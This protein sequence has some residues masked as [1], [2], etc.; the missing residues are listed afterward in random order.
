M[1]DNQI[2]EE[3]RDVK[4]KEATVPQTAVRSAKNYFKRNPHP[5]SVLVRKQTGIQLKSGA[6]F[7][8]PA[9]SSHSSRIIIPNKRFLEDDCHKVEISPK[10]PKVENLSVD[11]KKGNTPT[12][13]STYRCSR[14]EIKSES[15]AAA[16]D[17]TSRPDIVAE[18]VEFES[19]ETKLCT[20]EVDKQDLKLGSKRDELKIVSADHSEAD[21]LEFGADVKTKTIETDSLKSKSVSPTGSILQKPKLRLDQT[22]VD[23]SKVEFAKS[24]RNQMAQET[25]SKETQSKLS[26]TSSFP[27]SVSSVTGDV[28]SSE[29]RS[30][31]TSVQ[32]SNNTSSVTCSSW[33]SRTGKSLKVIKY[34]HKA[35]ALFNHHFH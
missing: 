9:K 29:L 14:K 25:Q 18:D 33:T 4:N 16:S 3:T 27:A 2:S 7:C 22:A 32:S 34:S 12:V 6:V 35:H 10:K 19:N 5:K 17:I 11:V 8:L 1:T 30:I 21:K 28:T 31:S 20:S 26:D 23:R 13:P 15:E 24:L